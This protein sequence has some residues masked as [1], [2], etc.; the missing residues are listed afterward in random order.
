MENLYANRRAELM[1]R[2][3]PRGAA[4]IHGSRMARRNH[5]VE[6]KSRAP[7]DLLYLTG[8]GEPESFAVLTPWRDQTFTMFVRARDQE[9]ETWTGR[10]LG[11][12][13]AIEKLG[14]SRAFPVEELQNQ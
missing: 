9:K 6:H 3:G 7:S 11:V 2:I 10:R 4:L 1:R 12:E 14:A 8:F 5:D 13:G